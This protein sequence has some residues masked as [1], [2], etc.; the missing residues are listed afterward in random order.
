MMLKLILYTIYVEN[1]S[2]HNVRN[3]LG[4]QVYRSKTILPKTKRERDSWRN[5]KTYEN[6]FGYFCILLCV[7][8]RSRNVIIFLRQDANSVNLE[9]FLQRPT[10]IQNDKNFFVRTL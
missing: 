2:V 4:S 9:V 8:V 1:V 10:Y 5:K 3:N 7:G 6:C